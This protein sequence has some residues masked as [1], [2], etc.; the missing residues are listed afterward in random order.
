MY[1]EEGE[2]REGTKG[3]KEQRRSRK[4]EGD[5]VEEVMEKGERERERGRERKD[6]RVTSS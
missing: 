4:G 1:V 6:I 3:E 2:T 5:R